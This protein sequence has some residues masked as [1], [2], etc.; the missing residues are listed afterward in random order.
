MLERLKR[1]PARIA[2]LVRMVIMLVA[3]FGFKLPDG[4]A[5]AIYAII[6]LLTTEAGVRPNVTPNTLAVERW[7]EGTNPTVSRDKP[8]TERMVDAPSEDVMNAAREFKAPIV[9]KPWNE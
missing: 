5:F 1:E 4:A 8:M 7:Q 3:E 6:E 9:N 2:M